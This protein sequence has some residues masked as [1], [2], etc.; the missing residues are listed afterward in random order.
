MPGSLIQGVCFT[1]TRERVI[2]EIG[3]GLV[4]GGSGLRMDTSFVY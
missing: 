4:C 2:S 1:K 3:G